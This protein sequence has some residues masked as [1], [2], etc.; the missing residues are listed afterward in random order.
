LTTPCRN[1]H[2]FER[3][4]IRQQWI[5]HNKLLLTSDNHWRKFK[6]NENYHSR[7]TI[8][9]NY[10][11]PYPLITINLY[12]HQLLEVMYVATGKLNWLHVLWST[13][14]YYCSVNTSQ[15]FY[16]VTILFTFSFCWHYSIVSCIEVIIFMFL[17]DLLTLYWVQQ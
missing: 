9:E 8:V 2:I 13:P 4:I 11:R 14:L 15:V 7:K 1:I 10:S 3:P 17:L 6:L 16:V 5:M 12:N